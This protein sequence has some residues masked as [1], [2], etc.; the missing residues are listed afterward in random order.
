MKVVAWIEKKLATWVALMG[1]VFV[2]SVGCSDDDDG[3]AAVDGGTD[4]AVDASSDAEQAD[5]Q[6]DA[7]AGSCAQAALTTWEGELTDVS[8]WAQSDLDQTYFG[9]A[10]IFRVLFERYSPEP[11]VGTFDLSQGDDANFGTC[12]HCLYAFE[13]GNPDTVYYA[14]QGTLELRQDPYSRRF[15]MS[16]KGLRL[17]ESTV[18]EGRSH[19]PVPDGDCITI[20]DFEIDE[21]FVPAKWTCDASKFADGSECHCDCGDFDPDCNAPF[22]EPPPEP[23]DCTE[24]QRCGFDPVSGSTLCIDKCD[25]GARSGCADAVCVFDDAQGSD[26][27]IA[28]SERF[29]D[30]TVGESCGPAQGLQKYCNLTQT[31]SGTF[32]DGYCD[33]GDMCRAICDAEEDCTEQGHSCRRFGA[34]DQGY[35]YCGPPPQDG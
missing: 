8:V 22:P 11:D 6:S 35:G 18:G 32:A 7:S 14:D 9:R 3:N 20:P 10:L 4:S 33:A 23:V 17:V 25:W 15:D 34:P 21:V 28:Q 1:M 26:S 31:E 13:D 2:L 5:A 16:V 29:A 27:C 24:T 19:T 30:V 12:R